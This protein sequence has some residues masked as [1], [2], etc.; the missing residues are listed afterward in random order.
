MNARIVLLSC[1]VA[2]IS[3]LLLLD[4]G[5]SAQARARSEAPV[6]FALPVNRSC[7]VTLDARS[8]GRASLAEE[9]QEQAGFVHENAAKG[10]V[11]RSDAEWVVLKDGNRENWIPRDKILMVRIQP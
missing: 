11:V 6:P 4:G 8:S 7:I 10:V 5:V 9:L 3:L 1:G 2:A